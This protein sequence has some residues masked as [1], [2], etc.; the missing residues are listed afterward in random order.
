M[1]SPG[2]DDGRQLQAIAFHSVTTLALAGATQLAA[3]RQAK[4]AAADRTSGRAKAV[5]VSGSLL[6]TCIS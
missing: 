6:F 5:M 4:P 1:P 3:N 2:R